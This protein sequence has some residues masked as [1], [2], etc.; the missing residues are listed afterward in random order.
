MR[1]VKFFICLGLLIIPAYLTGYGYFH[2]KSANKAKQ[3]LQALLLEENALALDEEP[4]G[5]ILYVRDGEDGACYAQ[6]K[7]VYKCRTITHDTSCVV[8]TVSY[9][10][11]HKM[12]KKR[13]IPAEEYHNSTGLD[14]THPKDDQCNGYHLYTVPEDTTMHSAPENI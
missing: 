7:D 10:L 13:P 9:A 8:T 5:Q 14:L 12:Y 4:S 3:T 11:L 2:Y 6:L 1:K